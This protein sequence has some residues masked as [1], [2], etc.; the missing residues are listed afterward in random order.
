MYA[1]H[2]SPRCGAKTKNYAGRPCRSP[3]VRGKKRCR[4]HGGGKGSGAQ[5]KNRNARTHGETTQEAK[6]FR[7]DVKRAIQDSKVLLEQL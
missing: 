6:L 4:L 2:L 1:Y 7:A 3:A 5:L